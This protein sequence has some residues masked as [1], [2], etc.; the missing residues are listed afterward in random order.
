MPVLQIRNGLFGAQSGFSGTSAIDDASISVSDTTLGVDTHALRDSV[1]LVPVG[2]RFTT[3]GIATIR[4]VSATQNSQQWTLTIDATGGTFTLTLNSETT[5]NIAYDATS[6]TVQT[7]L[8]ALASVTAGDVTVS[9]DGPH[10]ITAAGALANISTNT[11]TSDAALLT[12][13]TSTATIAV[14]QDGTTTWQVTFTPAIATGSV[15]ADDDVIT[16]YPERVTFKINQDGT[17]AWTEND[18]TIIDYDRD[19]IDGFRLGPEQP[20]EVNVGTPFESLRASSGGSLTFYE[21]LHQLGDAASWLGSSAGNV[22]D[23]YTVDLFWIDVPTCNSEEATVHIFPRFRKQ[24]VSADLAG[25][26][27]EV[28]GIC[29]ATKPEITRTTNNADAYGIIY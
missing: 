4:T 9:G 19:L 21:A 18:E 10:T 5:G 13:A 29:I 6:A 3:A 28:S 22:C 23:P 17:L 24:T 8:E 12:G 11:L 7:A 15:P 20:M 2:A 25:G 26:T 1:T 14:V 16:W 27:V